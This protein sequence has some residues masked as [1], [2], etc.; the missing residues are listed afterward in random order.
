MSS[1]MKKKIL[2]EEQIEGELSFSFIINCKEIHL[3]AHTFY[4]LPTWFL[5]YLI[6]PL[7]LS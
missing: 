4:A 6:F 3:F 7:K 5:E 1:F 2:E